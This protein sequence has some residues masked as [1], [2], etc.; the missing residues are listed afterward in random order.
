[1]AS[2]FEFAP[3]RWPGCGASF[4]I[5]ISVFFIAL[6]LAET[7]GNH[8]EVDFVLEARILAARNQF[9]VLSDDRDERVNP[10][11]IAFGEIAE[12]VMLHQV[13]VAGM[14]DADAN[15][16]VIIADMLGNRT[17]AIMSGDAAADFH[18][19]LARR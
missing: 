18:P 17:Q 3:R 12:H 16:A 8:G 7:F 15:A 4:W 19:H 9:G 14:T 10:A 2:Q 13:L 6:R 5:I 11:A 1:M